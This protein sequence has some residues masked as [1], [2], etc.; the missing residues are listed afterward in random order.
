MLITKQVMSLEDIRHHNSYSNS[1]VAGMGDGISS[2]FFLSQPL[3]V[4][5]FSYGFKAFMFPIFNR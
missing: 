1:G 5:N 3:I 4:N 2:V